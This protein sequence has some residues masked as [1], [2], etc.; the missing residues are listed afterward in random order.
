M[1]TVHKA[2]EPKHLCSGIMVTHLSYNELVIGDTVWDVDSGL[3]QWNGREW[4]SKDYN[5]WLDEQ[6]KG[7]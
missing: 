7:E 5:K 6:I 4:V 2:R 3:Y 1:S